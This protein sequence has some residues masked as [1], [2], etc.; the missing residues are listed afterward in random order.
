MKICIDPGH[1]GKFEPGAVH[2]GENG[3]ILEHELPAFNFKLALNQLRKQDNPNIGALI[4]K[5]IQR[6]LD[7]KMQFVGNISFDDRVHNA[8]CKKMP[9]LDLYPYTQTALD[10]R[11][12]HKNL[13]SMFETPP[14]LQNA[15]D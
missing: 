13:L 2:Y 3:E 5:I 9:F 4:C 14:I 6:H 1:S 7:L 8:V 10:L 12:C 11:D 15:V